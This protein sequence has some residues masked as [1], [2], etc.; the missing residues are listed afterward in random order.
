MRPTN[1][2][3]AKKVEKITSPGMY[4]DGLGLWLQ[5]KEVSTKDGPS[6]AKSWVFRYRGRYLGLGPTHTVNLAEARV[7]ARQ[8]RQVLLD[9]QD[10]IALKSATREARK[11]VELATKLERAR[12]TTF[13]QR[14]EEYIEA[15]K[16]SWRNPKHASQ[17]ESTLAAYAYPI[18][19]DLPVSGIDTRLVQKVLAPIWHEKPETASRLRGR[20]EKI[21]D[22][23]KVLGLRDGENPA[24]WKGHLDKLLAA[25]QKLRAV[26]HHP[27]L[28]SVEMPAFMAELRG[29]QGVSARALEFAVLTVARTSEVIAARWD[30]FDFKEAV[31]TVP[32]A[33]MKSG[34][35]HRVPLSKRAVEILNGLPKDDSGFTFMGTKDGS[36]LSNMAMLELMKHMR[37][38]YVPHGFRSTFRDWAGD[39]TNYAREVIE[40][41]LAH[42]I[43]DRA[44]AS[45]RR[46]DALE[47]RRQLMEAW[48]RYCNS[49]VKLSGDV[50]PLHGAA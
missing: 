24:R 20:I 39:R 45:Y 23:A 33:R 8:A 48:A 17:W 21:L 1:K 29:R 15:Q 19:G 10:P 30:E 31:W 13:K 44:E 37:P 9:G 46:S 43:P 6:I 27:A 12:A 41:A 32:A 38:G 4:G 14:A 50:V 47:K 22:S 28:P 35:E 42:R 40:H 3:T 34:K 5:V 26:R 7:R 25:K 16:A 36:H 2:L 49:P 11:A 18:I